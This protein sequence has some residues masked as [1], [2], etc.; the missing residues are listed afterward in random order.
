MNCTSQYVEVFLECVP[1]DTLKYEYSSS[2]GVSVP[3]SIDGNIRK[4]NVPFP[5]YYGFTRDYVSEDG[6]YLDVY[7]ITDSFYSR[8][9]VVEA[10]I[11]NLILMT[12]NGVEDSK[13]LCT[14]ESMVTNVEIAMLSNF[15]LGYSN[16]SVV[17]DSVVSVKNINSVKRLIDEYK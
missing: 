3:D 15:L 11:S 13:L 10:K 4:V 12:D 17:I 14:A 6:D 7:I 2:R 5:A 16:D 9:E 8:N 1:S